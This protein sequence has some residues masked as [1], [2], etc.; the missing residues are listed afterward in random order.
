MILNA[1]AQNH[2]WPHNNWYAAR[3]RAPGA[4]WIFLS[5][6]AEFGIGLIPSGYSENTFE[7]LFGRGGNLREILEGLLDSPLYQGLFM[8]RA[9]EYVAGPLRSENVLA[10]IQLLHDWIRPDM[11]DE[12]ALFPQSVSTWLDNIRTMETFARNRGRIFLSHLRASPRLAAGVDQ[13]PQITSIDPSSILHDGDVVVRILGTRFRPGVELYFNGQRGEI[14]RRLFTTMLDVRVPFTPIVSGSV[15]VRIVDPELELANEYRGLLS[16]S[17]PVPSI[18]RIE[19][20]RGRNDGGEEVRI[21]G[22]NFLAGVKVFFGDHEAPSV[23]PA[24]DSTTELRVETPPGSG[25]VDVRVVNTLEVDGRTETIESA[26]HGR[27]TFEG[28]PFIRGDATV[29]GIVDVSDAVAILNYLFTGSQGLPCLVAADAD[30][31]SMLELTDAL[32]LLGYL[33][34][35]D[36]PLLPPFPDCG[37]DPERGVLLSCDGPTSC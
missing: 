28:T 24:A 8:R 13:S 37:P 34:L 3:Q 25:A 26:E 35:G 2:D 14:V 1:W 12:M 29:D 4:K 7:W 31:N 19:P 6:D 33:F 30:R 27:F 23:V 36:G 17:Y 11:E 9:E 5:W 21:V 18:D 16:I 32:R 20:D 15:T 22:Q 10:R